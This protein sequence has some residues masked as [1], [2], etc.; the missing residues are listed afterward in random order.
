MIKLANNV[1]F[2]LEKRALL[3]VGSFSPYNSQLANYGIYAGGGGLA[4]AGIGALVN[5]L[6]GESKLRGALIGGGLGAGA[7]VGVKGLADAFAGNA[8]SILREYVRSGY[9]K[10]KAQ[11]Q[12][13]EALKRYKE[14]TADSWA[15][16][17]RDAVYG[18]LPEVKG[19]ENQKAYEKGMGELESTSIFDAIRDDA[20]NKRMLATLDSTY[21][22][23][24]SIDDA[25][26]GKTK[27]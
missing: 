4:G 3:T 22:L 18:K 6:R 26:K 27:D 13:A 12:D 5:A 19:D 2:M 17:L 10:N 23:D 8:Q 1:K 15:N 11:A 16:H 14:L 9:L 21:G 25:I 20:K 24:D 7:G